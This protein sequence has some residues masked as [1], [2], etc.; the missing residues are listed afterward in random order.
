M[1][2]CFMQTTSKEIIARKS[3]M[4]PIWMTFIPSTHIIVSGNRK[5]RHNI[6]I[7]PRCKSCVSLMNIYICF[8][9]DG[10]Y[11]FLTSFI[12]KQP[13]QLFHCFRGV[14][15]SKQKKNGSLLNILTLYPRWA[16]SGDFIFFTDFYG[17][18]QKPTLLVW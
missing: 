18:E 15:A 13:K 10:F 9:H 16:S 2:K 6:F 4:S 1:K 12:W 7:A 14:G 5:T 17:R 11:C 8:R 3:S